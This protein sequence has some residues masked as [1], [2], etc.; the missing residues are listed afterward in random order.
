MYIRTATYVV[1]SFLPPRYEIHYSQ[2]LLIEEEIYFQNG[3]W[4][5]HT[6]TPNHFT[7]VVMTPGDISEGM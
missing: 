5:K 6:V 7:S 2:V 4:K 1:N 3:T